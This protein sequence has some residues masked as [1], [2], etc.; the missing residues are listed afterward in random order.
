M[1]SVKLQQFEG[2][3]ELLLGLIEERKLDITQVSLA[4]VTEE[5]L[6]YLSDHPEINIEELADF[7]VVA[8]KLIL[9]K[10]RVLL[11]QFAEGDEAEG[12]ELERQ[13]TMLREYLDASKVI[14]GIVLRHTPSYSREVTRL[15]LESVF[16]PPRHLTAFTLKGIMAAV[17]AAVAPIVSLPKAVIART[18]SIQEKIADIQRRIAN[19]VQ[20]SF[21]KLVAEAQNPTDVVVTFL[22]LLE[23]V[24]QRAIVVRQ[25][26]LFSD[27]GIEQVE[28]K[29]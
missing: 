2:P 17:I 27:I 10:S 20:L 16:S 24:K 29:P 22:A 23:L 26:T 28:G 8:A 9:I 4:Q 21:G 5:Y 15:P 18:V 6:R 19:H 13:L 11:P 1:Y 3:L 14:H 12:T 7:L 25:T